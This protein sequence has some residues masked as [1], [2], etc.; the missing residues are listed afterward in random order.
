MIWRAPCRLCN[1]SPFHLFSFLRVSA[2]GSGV[3]SPKY[4]LVVGDLRAPDRVMDALEAVGID[5]RQAL[6]GGCRVLDCV[7]VI[8]A[9]VLL[10]TLCRPLFLPAGSFNSF[11]FLFCLRIASTTQCSN[12]CAVR[13]RAHLSD[14]GGGRRDDC[15]LREPVCGGRLCAVRAGPPQRRLWCHHGCLARGPVLAQLHWMTVFFGG[16]PFIC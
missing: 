12:P 5:F 9:C 10:E 16:Y 8:A 7:R 15:R 14:G 2:E 3:V 4:R 6:W 11:F 13:V 1:T